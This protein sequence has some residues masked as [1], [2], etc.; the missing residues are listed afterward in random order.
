MV[1]VRGADEGF[2]DDRLRLGEAGFEVAVGPFGHGLAHRQLVVSRQRE[3][4]ARPFDGL[5]LDAAPVGD[6]AADMGVGAVGLQAVE[7]VDAERQGLEI[8]LDRLDRVL[9]LLFGRRGERHDR[10]PDEDRVVGEDGVPRIL[11]L[12]DF[13]R[14]HDADDAGH[15]HRLARVDRLD[16]GVRHGRR[17]NLEEHHAVGAEV[18]GVFGRAG[19]LRMEIRRGEVLA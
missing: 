12:L 1:R 18:L 9:G 5:Q 8:D 6:V 16:P 19:N 10:L 3:I 2:L 4:L 14:K 7:R 13:A 11:R 17:K 15:F